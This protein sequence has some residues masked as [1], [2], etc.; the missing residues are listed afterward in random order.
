MAP[1][2]NLTG[3]EMTALWLQYQEAKDAFN[4]AIRLRDDGTPETA[5]AFERA[6]RAI[7]D[8]HTVDLA[9]IA[10]KLRVLNDTAEG[11]EIVEVSCATSLPRVLCR[12]NAR[13]ANHGTQAQHSAPRDRRGGRAAGLP[14][15][16]LR[17]RQPHG[18]NRVVF[19]GLDLI[20]QAIGDVTAT[21]A[22]LDEIIANMSDGDAKHEAIDN[23][24]R[25]LQTDL[26]TLQRANAEARASILRPAIRQRT[27]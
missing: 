2:Q 17:A 14:G 3:A 26:A 12:R 10:I 9:G 24:F 7:M 13:E 27:A 19:N 16:H 5:D 15:Q 23:L 21:S 6:Q 11:G 1:T 8:A 18:A 20:D 4:A 25:H 22:V